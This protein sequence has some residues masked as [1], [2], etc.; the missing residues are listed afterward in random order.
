MVLR[1]SVLTDFGVCPLLSSLALAVL[2]ELEVV[3]LDCLAQFCE[4]TLTALMNL[5]S[6]S[7]RHVG[8]LVLLHLL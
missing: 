2:E 4:M 6:E 8:L 7:V 5:N 1:P 3:N